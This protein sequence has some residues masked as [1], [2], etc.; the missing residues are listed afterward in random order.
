MKIRYKLKNAQMY[1]SRQT[2]NKIKIGPR[3]TDEFTPSKNI[4]QKIKIKQTKK[5]I[6][7]L[8]TLLQ[9]INQI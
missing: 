4:V 3:F 2:G 9:I 5:G 6:I 8:P 1:C 7:P